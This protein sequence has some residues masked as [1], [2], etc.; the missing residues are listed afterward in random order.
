MTYI[1]GWFILVILSMKCLYIIGAIF[2]VSKYGAY[3][4]DNIDDSNAIQLT[5]DAAISYGLNNTVIF[6]AGIYNLSST[7]TIR[8]ATNLTVTGQGMDQ[9]F[10]VGNSPIQ[11]LLVE[12]CQGT[13]I[14]AFSIDFDPLP[15]T[16]GYVV[17]VNDTFIDVQVKPPHR[18]DIG[19]Q[20]DAILRYDPTQM[21]PAFGPNTYE[22]YRSKPVTANTSLVSPG[23]VR[24]PIT[25]SS[26]FIVG[27]PVVAFYIRLNHAIYVL[28][29]VDFMVES[30]TIFTSWCMGLVTLRAKRLTVTHF[31]VLRRDERW[32]ST[33]ADC[34]HFADAREYVNIFDSKCEAMGDD[35]LNIHAV[36]FNV[37]Q[38]VN[39][40]ALI[41][42]SSGAADKLHVGIGTRLEFSSNQQPFTVYATATVT[43]FEMISSNSALY[44]FDTSVNVS[45][46]DLTCVA[47]T[48][49]LTIR[50]FTVAN[51]R[52]RGVLLETRNIDMKQSL[53]NRTSGPAVYFQP[54]LFWHEGPAA[55]N[56]SLSE[57]VYINCNE[58]IAQHAG[59][60]I[61]LPVPTQLV[62]V[63]H[64]VKIT[65]SSFYFGDYSQ[66]LLQC[67][68]ADNVFLSGNYI[69]TN[70]STP[71]ISLCNS[72]N[73][74]ASNN[75]VVNSQSK[76]DQYYSLNG[77]YPCQINLTSLID[78][79]PSAF[80]SSFPPP[81]LITNPS[82]PQNQPHSHQTNFNTKN[83]LNEVLET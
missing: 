52:A 31:H 28:D 59:F 69:E 83:M 39:S 17:N 21:R 53:F 27:D 35:G 44:V 71:L 48:P 58:G 6:G 51:N 26:Q 60:I 1:N 74:S 40:S 3:P 20:V 55:R 18:P 77:T 5:I 63:V 57:N 81:A 43:S 78:L 32:A 45:I 22:L 72:R 2:P 73:I 10:L 49:R 15:F 75:T 25:S 19:Q 68:N 82:L 70:D 67:F 79:P 11:I 24:L 56:A 16:A 33:I 29:V 61:V 66:G 7:I 62:P 65:A 76:I 34:M 64:D 50:N 80:N 37:S 41:I 54:S 9:T 23:I 46:G 4:N 36:Y 38:I 42:Q 30:I 13:T 12:Y 14:S 8:N 47:D